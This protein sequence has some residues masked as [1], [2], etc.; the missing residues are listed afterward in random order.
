MKGAAEM[1][2]MLF[3]RV[4]QG[5][6]RYNLRPAGVKCLLTGKN[7]IYKEWV[8]QGRPRNQMWSAT[9]DDL[10]R[11]LTKNRFS[12]ETARLLID[13]YPRSK[14][15]VALLEIQSVHAWFLG[16][17]GPP[18]FSRAILILR[19]VFRREF[20]KNSVTARTRTEILSCLPE[21]APGARPLSS[22]TFCAL[23]KNAEPRVTPGE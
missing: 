13:Y 10:I 16:K 20:S 17:G 2:V 8:R 5:W 14:T 7:L 3:E 22:Q 12:A 21:P 19:E 6:E 15:R 11:T 1:K 9:A 4:H 23:D 18:E